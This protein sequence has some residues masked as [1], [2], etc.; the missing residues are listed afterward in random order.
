MKRRKCTRI[1]D[2]GQATGRH[3]PIPGVEPGH[4]LL[5]LIRPYVRH[6]GDSHRSAWYMGSR[7]LLDFLLVY[8]AEGKGRFVIDGAT[9]DAEP[10]DLFWIPPDTPHSM[11]G[12]A[13]GMHC[14]Y[15][16]FDLV[17]RPSHSH[18]DFTIPAGMEDLGELKPLMHE[19]IQHPLL[20]KLKGRIRSHTNRH[21]GGLLQDICAEAARA[22]PFAGLRMSGMMTMVMAEILRGRA[23]LPDEQIAHAAF[24]EKAADQISRQCH[25]NLRMRELAKSCELSPSHF[26][27]LFNRHFGMTPREYLRRARLRRARELMVGT[28]M[29]I[30]EI[31]MKT[32]FATVH[33]FSRAFRALDGISPRE[34][35]RCAREVHTR[36]EGRKTPYSR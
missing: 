1:A 30:S 4:E 10:G 27:L 11:E 31:A 7:K 25:E 24:L 26:R 36:V 3:A 2:D 23:G 15:V 29:T 6:C 13:P 14:P 33:S 20:K 19:R 22:Q 21:V 34:Y 9:F 16:H 28:G 17:Y 8:I 35:R 32:G 5:A 18:W 12:Y